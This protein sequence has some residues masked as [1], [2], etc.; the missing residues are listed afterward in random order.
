[1]QLPRCSCDIDSGDQS[2]NQTSGI[3]CV[4][5]VITDQ[6]D[7]PECYDRYV[8]ANYST[9]YP[10]PHSKKYKRYDMNSYY[11]PPVVFVDASLGR[12]GIGTQSPNAEL[13]VRGDINYTGGLTNIS[14]KR[15]KENITP[16]TDA[17]TIVEAINGVYYNKIATPDRPEAGVLAQDVQTVLP[18]A[19]SVIDPEN[20][21]LG[22]SYN[23]LI[24]VLVEAVKELKVKNDIKDQKIEALT[25]LVCLDRP[26]A[27]I[28]Q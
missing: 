7:G 8:Q 6:D 23:M 10:D 13:D 4:S 22:V 11:Y 20:G 15:L 18:E 16:I 25:D 27:G 5:P 17:L 14:D 19:V 9:G 28:C 26:E 1:M 12:L 3:D 24:P 2:Q 21:Y